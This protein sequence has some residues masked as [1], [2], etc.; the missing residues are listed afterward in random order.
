MNQCIVHCLTG[1][2][3]YKYGIEE[4]KKCVVGSLDRLKTDWKIIENCEKKVWVHKRRSEYI[5]KR[6]YLYTFQSSKK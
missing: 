2:R 3:H 5:K 4:E 6:N 1:R